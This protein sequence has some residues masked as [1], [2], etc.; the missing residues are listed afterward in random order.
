MKQALLLMLFSL[1][2]PACASSP[3]AA[4]EIPASESTQ[5]LAPGDGAPA[6]SLPDQAGAQVSLNHLT[7]SGPSVLVFYRGAW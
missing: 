6:F 1:G 7:A 2:L 3:A 5:T 4:G